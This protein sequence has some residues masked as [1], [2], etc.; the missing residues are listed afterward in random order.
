MSPVTHHTGSSNVLYMYRIGS[1][2]DQHS[3][4]TVVLKMDW[5]YCLWVWSSLWTDR[6]IG[7]P[8]PEFSNVEKYRRIQ[9]V[10]K[11]IDA[12]NWSEKHLQ[13][14]ETIWS[15]SVVGVGGEWMGRRG[16]PDLS[17]I[18]TASAAGLR[19][20]QATPPHSTHL[21]SSTAVSKTFLTWNSVPPQPWELAFWP[22]LSPL[23]LWIFLGMPSH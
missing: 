14:K 10:F 17:A 16:I 22:G 7:H 15:E 11:N 8:F 20:L 19:Y 5:L 18:Y 2:T 1:M 6:A 9:L 12:F 21:D 3:T 13:G 4:A 23:C